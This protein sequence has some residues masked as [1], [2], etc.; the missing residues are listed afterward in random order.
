MNIVAATKNKHKIE[1]IDKITKDFGMNILS[2]DEVIDPSLEILEDG[3]TFFEN[4]YKKAFEIMK[5]SN[6]I[7][8]SDDS[9]LMVDALDG[10]PGVISA[11]FAGEDSSDRENNEKL[12]SMLLDIPTEKR[13]AKFVSVITLAYP[14]E[15]YIQAYGEC[16]GHVILEA[17][18]ENGFGY[19]PYFVPDGFDKT[20]AELS[21]EEKNKISHR[22]NALREL[23]NK[24]DELARKVD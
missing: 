6:M 8:I 1:E 7:S 11:R 19:D 17:R 12:V 20:F 10:A 13:T 16:K 9:G 22:A 15:S 23:K 3:V 21:Q 2:R 24:L 5:L 4:S 18:G 14:D